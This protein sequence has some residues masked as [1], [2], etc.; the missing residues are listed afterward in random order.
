[1]PGAPENLLVAHPI[2]KNAGVPTPIRNVSRPSIEMSLVRTLHEMAQVVAV[3]AATYMHEQ[4]CPFD[5]EFDGNDFCAAHIIGRIDGEPAGCI[6]IRYFA[7]FVKF[8]R[9]AVRR[10]FRKSKLAFRLVRE[11]MR[12][13]ARKGYERVYGHARHDLVKFWMT[14]GFRPIPGRPTFTF[15]DVEYVEM[16]GR[17]TPDANRVAIGDSPLRIIRPEGEWDTP[18]VLERKADRKR[19]QRI[20]A[21]LRHLRAAV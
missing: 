16:E 15:S 5:E 11:A 19:Q 9:L 10:E 13:A 17:I 8:E 7:G 3:R 6:R 18:G 21:S 20:G 2:V 14:F 1:M 12:L 4:E